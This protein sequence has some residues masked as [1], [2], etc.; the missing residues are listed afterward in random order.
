MNKIL[1]TILC[2]AAVFSA[3]NTYGEKNYKKYRPISYEQYEQERVREEQAQS[4]KIEAIEQED[5]SAQEPQVPADPDAATSMEDLTGEQGDDVVESVN[6]TYGE[7]VVVMATKQISLGENATYT[8]MQTFQKALDAAYSTARAR[9]HATGFTYALSPAGA[10]NPLSEMEVQCILSE[11]LS[12][13]TGKAVCDT[14][15]REI[16]SEYNNDTT[17]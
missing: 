11:S 13:A 17:I 14:F 15:F 4:H 3:C 1:L 8:D 16:V 9:Y 6:S 10:V 7:P 2:A 12:N 5:I